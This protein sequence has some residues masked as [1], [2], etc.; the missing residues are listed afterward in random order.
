MWPQKCPQIT[1]FFEGILTFYRLEIYSFLLRGA[2]KKK[3]NSDIIGV[4]ISDAKKL[5]QN[6]IFVFLPK[7]PAIADPR[8]YAIVKAGE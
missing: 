6:P 3:Y 1:C 8:R 5:P 2:V 7:T 4:K